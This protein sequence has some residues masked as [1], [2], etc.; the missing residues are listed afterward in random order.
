MTRHPQARKDRKP[1]PPLDT[2][3]LRAIAIRYAERYQTSRARLLRLLNQKI[4]QRGWDPGAPPPDPEAIADKMV[5]LGYVND[6][7]FA[8]ARTRGMVRRGLG[9][10]RVQAALSAYGVGRDVVAEALQEV[11]GWAAAVDFARRK[12]LG[13]FGERQDDP[14]ARM[15]QLGAMARAGHGFDVARRVVDA[16]SLDELGED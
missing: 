8:Q 15:K 11:D 5:E 4:R 3:A 6:T 1:P 7:S 14:K 2:E 9:A 10:G 12:R 16:R 13:P